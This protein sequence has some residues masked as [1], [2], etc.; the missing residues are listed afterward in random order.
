MNTKTREEV[1]HTHK[2]TT[3]LILGC[4]VCFPVKHTPT[5]LLG[6]LEVY[7]T[8]DHVNLF[9]GDNQIARVW[10]KDKADA[11]V[12][13]VNSHEA[14]LEAAKEAE[15]VLAAI[16]GQGNHRIAQHLRIAINKA[17]GKQIQG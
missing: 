9:D 5:P 2:E 3:S 8:G 13:A 10:D 15:S 17:E 7:V 11:I 4:P 1:K 12:R 16:Q 6:K 14:L